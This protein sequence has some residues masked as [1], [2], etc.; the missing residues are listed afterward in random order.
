MDAVMQETAAAGM[1]LARAREINKWLFDAAM[2]K[3][4]IGNGW[5]E[6]L[7]SVSLAEMLQA[8]T[9]VEFANTN[10]A[11]ETDAETGMKVKRLSCV[12]D[13]RLIAAIYV[14]LHHAP[15]PQAI[16]VK[17]GYGVAVLPIDEG[18]DARLHE[19]RKAN[20]G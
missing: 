20:Q 16:A 13:C 3:E 11:Y 9:L 19:R 17:G 8:T 6:G 10:G 1:T 5:N 2:Y 4:G 14:L 12:C 15:S 18:D 7:K